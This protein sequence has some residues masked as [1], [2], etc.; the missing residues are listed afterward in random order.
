[1]KGKA[2]EEKTARRIKEAARDVFLAKGYDGATMK[3]IADRSQVN[4]A[5]LHYYYRGKNN[6]FLLVFEEEFKRLL[7]IGRDSL[8]DPKIPMR[9]PS[10]Y[11]SD[12]K[13]LTP[14]SWSSSS[15][16]PNWW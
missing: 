13:Y 10:T 9:E 2:L 8:L 7:Q 4:K 5:L 6:L 12:F 3:A 15:T 16:F 14:A 11:G 1:M